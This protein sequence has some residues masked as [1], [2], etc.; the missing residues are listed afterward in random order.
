[1]LSFLPGIPGADDIR[2]LARKVDTARHHGV[3]AGV[4]LELDL[5]SAPPETA[6]FDPVRLITGA[7]RPMLLRDAVAAADVREV[8]AALLPDEERVVE[9]VAHPRVHRHAFSLPAAW[10]QVISEARGN[11]TPRMLIERHAA[12]GGDRDDAYRAL[13][14]ALACGLVCCRAEP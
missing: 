1:M 9:P 4:V 8:L 5:Q 11:A 10:E 14:L 2:D 6:G 13:F 7:G 3:P 12:S